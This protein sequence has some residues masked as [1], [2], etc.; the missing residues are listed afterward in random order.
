MLERRAGGLT[1]A[2]VLLLAASLAALSPPPTKQ[3]ALWLGVLALALATGAAWAVWHASRQLLRQLLD[4]ATTPPSAARPFGATA[5]DGRAVLL[6]ATDAFRRRLQSAVGERRDAREEA[7]KTD[8][9][10][11]EFLR[12]LSHELRTPLNAIMG[13]SQV[14]LEEIDG[15]IDASQREDLETVLA[16]GEHLTELVDD[17]LDLAAMQSPHFRL[18]LTKVDVVP[19]LESVVGL[20]SGQRRAIHVALRLEVPARPLWV[21][22]DPKR[23]RQIV[24]NLASNAL[25]FTE[26]G[27]VCLRVGPTTTAAGPGVCVAVEDTGPGIGSDDLALIFEEFHQGSD[28]RRK[29]QG[30]GLGLA[31][32]QRLAKLHGGAIKVHSVVGQGSTFEL[33][34][35]PW[36]EGP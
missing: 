7:E 34:L 1:F 18:A 29:G 23:L 26:R 22:G 11:T 35:Q 8:R 9:Y 14:L 24:T 5:F 27:Q 10:E 28:V 12:S 33:W 21:Q 6:R 32:C 2:L 31:I 25:K 16:S 30:F 36:R 13:F 19:L 4:S 17:V 20:L 15:P 3:A